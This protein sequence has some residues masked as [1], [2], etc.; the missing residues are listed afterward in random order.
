MSRRPAWKCTH[1]GQQ[2]GEVVNGAVRVW[3]PAPLIGPDAT[4][5]ECPR[6]RVVNVWRHA[7][8]VK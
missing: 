3:A 7:A 5:I 6:C 4:S 8:E 1:C 2:L